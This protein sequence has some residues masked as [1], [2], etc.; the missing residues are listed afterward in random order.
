MTANPFHAAGHL[1]ARPDYRRLWVAGA[2]TGIT[3]WLEFV[4]LGIYAYELTRSAPMVALLAV[5]RMAPYVVLGFVIGALADRFDR[6]HLLMLAS[7]ML[8][9][10][11]I[12][13]AILTATGHASYAAVATATFIGGIFWTIDMPVRRRLVRK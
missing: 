12:G 3:R 6:R 1:F 11:S 9:L 8:A 4:A 10:T 7:L 5:I 13:M 2:V